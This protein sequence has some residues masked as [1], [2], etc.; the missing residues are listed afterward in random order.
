VPLGLLA[1]GVV[2]TFA[3]AGP[4]RA[5]RGVPRLDTR[6]L[7]RLIVP[8]VSRRLNF[9]RE[10]GSQ[11]EVRLAIPLES[12]PAVEERVSPAVLGTRASELLDLL[13]WTLEGAAAD[14]LAWCCGDRPAILYVLLRSLDDSRMRREPLT[15]DD[16]MA[17]W[18]SAQFRD[19]VRGLLEPVFSDALAR[20][21]VEAVQV[22]AEGRAGS[23]F[24]DVAMLL[25]P[26]PEEHVHEAVA[27]LT[28]Q[29]MLETLGEG[30]CRL[31]SN[32][33]GVLIADLFAGSDSLPAQYS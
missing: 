28:Q 22:S 25:E 20:S 26:Q 7:L 5:A 12:I 27:A 1:Q 16:V 15:V 3:F 8:G 18:R 19:A 24:E 2:L 30:R 13:D 31:P 29:G 10:L 17:A 21:V 14:L 33:L 4:P 6:S 23:A 32:G 11:L 9:L